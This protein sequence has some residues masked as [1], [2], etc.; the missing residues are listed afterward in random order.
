MP[1][2]GLSF[3]AEPRAAFEALR[4]HTAIA[5]LPRPVWVLPSGEGRQIDDLQCHLLGALASAVGTMQDSVHRFGHAELE[6]ELGLR[7]IARHAVKS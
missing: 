7:V 6:T 5:Q 3:E 4:P 1:H 2:L